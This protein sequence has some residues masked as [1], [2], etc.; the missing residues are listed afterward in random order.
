MDY[1][2]CYLQRGVKRMYHLRA[3]PALECLISYE[4]MK[5]SL[6]AWEYHSNRVAYYFKYCILDH[7][8]KLACVVLT[9]SNLL[10]S[11]HDFHQLEDDRGGFQQ[12]LEAEEP[13]SIVGT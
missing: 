1:R 11:P 6:I 10:V 5:S 4:L 12:L 2:Y 9:T 7:V 13:T 3:L 8:L